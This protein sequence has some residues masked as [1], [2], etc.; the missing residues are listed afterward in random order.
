MESLLSS[1]HSSEDVQK[2]KKDK[3]QLLS[4][5]VRCF[6]IETISRVGGHFGSNLG[7]VELTV[8]LH[9]VFSPE[10]DRIIWDVGHQS[11]AHKLLSGRKDRLE[12]IRKKGGLA[13]FPKRKESITD[14]FGTGH[15]STSISAATG[16]ALAH[17]DEKNPPAIIAVIGDGALTGGMAFEGLNH[18]GDAGADILVILNDNTMSISPNVGAMTQYLTRLISSSEYASIR[19]KGKRIL[20]KVPIFKEAAKRVERHAKGM[21]A[22]S[23]FFEEMG[24][25]YFGPVDGNNVSVLVDILEN[26]KKRSGPRLL[27]IYTKKGKGCSHAEKDALALHAVSA[28]DLKTGKKIEKKKEETYTDIFSRWIVRKAEK[29][30]TLHAV[31]PAMREGSGLAAFQK[32]YP[33]RFHDVGIAE[34]HA[35]TFAAGLAC[36][37]QKPVVA[38]YSTFLQR[39]YDQVIHDV[40]IQNLDMLF[41]VDRAGIVG[42]DGETH[43]GSFDLSFLRCVPNVVIM[44]PSSAEECERMLDFGFSYSGPV[45]VRYPRSEAVHEITD[46][47]SPLVLGTARRLRRGKNIAIISFGA[48]LDRCAK[49]A[50][51][52][53]ATL[54]DMRFVKPLD[55]QILRSLAKNHTMIVTVEDNAISAGAGGSVCEYMARSEN[56]VR[57]L[58]LGLPDAFLGHGTRDEI[59]SEAGLDESGIEKSIMRAV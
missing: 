30:I 58:S 14:A 59:L 41:A 34:Q 47:K 36:E 23:T 19:E 15:S 20:S 7:V 4:D 40:A 2:L 31:T 50:E 28:F 56:R 44:A 8:A 16:M 25:S 21:I 53:G 33:R 46:W 9:F 55:V 54:V 38:I 43:A 32:K 22:P 57:V 13:P 29:Q 3:L 5:E 37:K 17:R 52:L 24:F 39:A 11:Y 49:V 26:L 6:L 18:A 35:V 42:P 12:T 48:L 10:R 51:R 1:I 27:H 45:F